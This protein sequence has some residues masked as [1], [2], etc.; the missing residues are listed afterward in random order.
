M[1][2]RCSTHRPPTMTDP[3]VPAANLDLAA[4]VDDLFRLLRLKTT[5]IAMQLF[6]TV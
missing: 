1:M 4:L 6:E 5:P 2:G 3:V